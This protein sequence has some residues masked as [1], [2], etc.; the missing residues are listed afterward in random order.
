MTRT[1]PQAV[2]PEEL[3]RAERQR[4]TP[5][6]WTIRTPNLVGM[7]VPTMVITGGWNQEYEEIGK[8]IIGANLR[9]LTG[10]G[11]RPQ[12][13]PAANDLINGHVAAAVR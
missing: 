12:D 8:R 3:I 6:P 13:H 1:Q 4:L 9:T 2:R 5:G 11:H 10:Y 7:I